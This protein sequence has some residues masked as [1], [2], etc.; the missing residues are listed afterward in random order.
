MAVHNVLAAIG[1]FGGALLGGYL[2]THLPG[3]GIA[4]AGVPLHWEFALL[5][6]FVVSAVARLVVIATFMPR[7][8]EVRQVPELSISSL[9]F[10]VTRVHALSG[11]MFEIVAPRDKP[12][13][14]RAPAIGAA[15]AARP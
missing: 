13:S 7:L 1:T 6:V 15:R 12:G 14:A 4:V 9:V 2:A 10:R 11:L 5:A 8:K 3:D